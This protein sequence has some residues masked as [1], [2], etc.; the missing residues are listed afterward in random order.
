MRDD[1]PRDWSSK[2]DPHTLDLLERNYRWQMQLYAE[3]YAGK[4]DT[5]NYVTFLL[6]SCGLSGEI[7][8]R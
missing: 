1:T 6:E 2:I 7:T 8:E 3:E 4:G 5:A